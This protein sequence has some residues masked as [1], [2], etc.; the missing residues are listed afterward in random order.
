MDAR[1]RIEGDTVVADAGVPLGTLV[2]ALAPCGW[3]LPVVP[4]AARTTVGDAIAAD[5][6]GKNH[7]R[8]GTFGDHV[9]EM[10][11]HTPARGVVTM[12]P[13]IEPEA[14]RATV[15]GLGLTGLIRS[16]RLRLAPLTS[17]DLTCTDTP[18]ADLEAMLE[19]LRAAA[20]HHPYAVGWIDTRRAGSRT[21]GGVVT[22]AQPTCPARLA[23]R[24]VGRSA[25]GVRRVHRRISSAPVAGPADHARVLRARLRPRRR[26]SLPQVLFPPHAVPPRPAARGLVQHQFV[27]PFGAEVVLAEALAATRQAG[28]PATL[29][30]LKVFGG[31]GGGFLSFPIPGWS[32]ALDFPADPALAPLLDHLDERVAASGGRACLAEGSRLR[33]DLL[34]TMYPEL[35]RWRTERALL[36][37]DRVMSSDL[38]RRLRLFGGNGGAANAPST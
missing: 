33:P 17:W 14:F 13:R 6:H 11:V 38:A 3:T 12:G 1:F 23:P 4:G 31:F 21:G 35:P 24:D 27:V 18:A 25:S 16:A 37:P 28:H 10:T 9:R 22:A 5:V 20:D 8:W 32:L 36:D 7:V 15:G 30:V 29:A 19:R 34:D 2:R 26:S